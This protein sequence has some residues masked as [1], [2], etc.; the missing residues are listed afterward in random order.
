[1]FV[2]LHNVYGY[3]LW[4]CKY[5]VQHVTPTHLYTALIH[6]LHILLYVQIELMTL[7]PSATD[8]IHC[9][10]ANRKQLV[11]SSFNSQTTR[12]MY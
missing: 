5:T 10:C 1:M 12:E 9:A 11:L 3:D 6:N 7:H 2:T 8:Y 4:R